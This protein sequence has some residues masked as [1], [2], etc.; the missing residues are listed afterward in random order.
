M[1]EFLQRTGNVTLQKRIDHYFRDYVKVTLEERI[2]RYFKDHVKTKTNLP[3]YKN[4]LKN[5]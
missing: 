5:G 3:Y 1:N 4:P 2:V